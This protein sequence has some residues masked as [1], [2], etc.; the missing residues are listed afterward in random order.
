MFFFKKK[1]VEQV[2]A[3]TEK[4]AS[5][6]QR[7]KD[8]LEEIKSTNSELSETVEHTQAANVKL[9]LKLKK[10]LS[11]GNR[12]FASLSDKLLE[13][14]ALLLGQSVDPEIPKELRQQLMEFDEIEHVYECRTLQMGDEAL[15]VIRARFA[16]MAE[17][18]G[19]DLVDTINKIEAVLYAKFPI[20]GRIF[21]EPDDQ[22]EDC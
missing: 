22:F 11:S 6:A 12:T 20:F 21:V 13:T 9:A 17:Q 7:I 5:L 2:V 15:L 10:H 14:K 18:T 3:H 8:K 4:A 1:V 16:N 19:K